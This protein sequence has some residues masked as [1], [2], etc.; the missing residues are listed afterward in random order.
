MWISP[1]GQKQLFMIATP[2][3]NLAIRMRKVFAFYQA[4]YKKKHEVYK[5][6]SFGFIN[7]HVYVPHK[8]N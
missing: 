6:F 3:V 7:G 5:G 2:W 8:F 4:F 1:L